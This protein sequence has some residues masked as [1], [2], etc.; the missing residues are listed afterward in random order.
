MLSSGPTRCGYSLTRA[1]AIRDSAAVRAS[2]DLA[3]IATV[4]AF[5]VRSHYFRRIWLRRGQNYKLR[6]FDRP[7]HVWMG[8]VDDADEVLTA[9]RLSLGQIRSLASIGQ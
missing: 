2:S 4:R 9:A 7:A 6:H 8:L 1:E 3:S 5:C